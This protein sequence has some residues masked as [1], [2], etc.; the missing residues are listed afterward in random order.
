MSRWWSREEDVARAQGVRQNAAIGR[1]D[2]GGGGC[3]GG[4]GSVRRPMANAQLVAGCG[5]AASGVA[6]TVAVEPRRA[7][8]RDGGA[9]SG[10]RRGVDGES[11]S[12]RRVD[13]ELGGRRRIDGESAPPRWGRESKRF[14]ESR[15]ILVIK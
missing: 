13:G 1:G 7:D 2:A 8:D 14:G 15:G 11:G 10:G 5:H 3:R 6:R 9:K 4:D 12:Q